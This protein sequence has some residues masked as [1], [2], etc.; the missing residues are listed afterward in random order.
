MP[1]KPTMKELIDR[2][3][4]L[5]RRA[6]AQSIILRCIFNGEGMDGQEVAQYDGA[7]YTFNLYSAKGAHGG[8]VA[9]LFDSPHNKAISI[10]CMALDSLSYPMLPE[11]LPLNI[12]IERLKVARQKLIDSEAA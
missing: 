2:C 10:D 11:Y 5:E 3:D 9:V 8:Y 6:T 4:S 7:K 12:A 1:R